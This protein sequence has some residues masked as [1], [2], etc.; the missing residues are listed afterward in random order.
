MQRLRQ[1]MPL[2]FRKIL[3]HMIKSK[4]IQKNIDIH[5]KSQYYAD[6]SKMSSGEGHRI[7]SQSS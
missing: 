4:Y 1:I 3:K 7:E 5:N 6:N 2:M